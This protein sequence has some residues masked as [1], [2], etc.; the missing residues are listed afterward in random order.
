MARISVEGGNDLNILCGNEKLMDR[1]GI[2][3][4]FSHFRDNM[5]ALGKDGKTVV[6]MV[7]NNI[8]RLLISLEEAHVAKPE[9]VAVVNYMRDVMKLKVAMITGDN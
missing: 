7:V 2:D 9:A 3:L 8:P 1:A 4:S 5:H 6:C